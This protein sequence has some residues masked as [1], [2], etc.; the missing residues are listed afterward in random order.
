MDVERFRQQPADPL[1]KLARDFSRRSR[2]ENH[3]AQVLRLVLFQI[4]EDFCTA[5]FRQKEVDDQKIVR[6]ACEQFDRLRT[7]ADTFDDE[8]LALEDGL[9]EFENGDVIF[10]DERAIF[11]PAIHGAGAEQE[12]C[13]VG[14]PRSSVLS[15]RLSKGGGTEDRGPRTEDRG[16][17][18]ED[19]FLPVFTAD[20]VVSRIFAAQQPMTVTEQ[21]A[22]PSR[23]V[24]IVDDDASLRAAVAV[25][26]QVGGYDVIEAGDGEEAL[27]QLRLSDDIDLVICDIVMPKMN[28]ADFLEKARAIRPHLPFIMIT[29]YSGNEL[30][31][32]ALRNGAYTVL[33]KP[34]DPRAL[35]TIMGRAITSPVVLGVNSAAEAASVAASL[36]QCCIRVHIAP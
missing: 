1:E 18:T 20:N 23:T 32:K 2:G 16:P 29:G 9:H 33:S 15:P 6:D 12:H 26:V 4:I 3:A 11:P 30:M 28:G 13:R 7:V 8:V 31:G 36:D 25:N 19:A 35:L 21:T 17:Q 24:L 14:S 27:E 34:F 22:K 5:E 10:N